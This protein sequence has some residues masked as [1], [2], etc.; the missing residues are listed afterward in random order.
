[1][2]PGGPFGGL[3]GLAS[4]P[5]GWRGSGWVVGWVGGG[6]W[7]GGRAGGGGGTRGSGGAGSLAPAGALQG[8]GMWAGTVVPVSIDRV[9]NNKTFIYFILRLPVSAQGMLP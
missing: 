7:L 5:G 2:V 8:I 9:L 6:G 3:S 1:M 4:W